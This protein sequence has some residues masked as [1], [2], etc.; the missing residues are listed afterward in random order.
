MKVESKKIEIVPEF[1]PV[2]LKITLETV[3]E[4][5]AFYTIFN[6]TAITDSINMI[7]SYAIRAALTKDNPHLFNNSFFNK[8]VNSIVSHPSCFYQQQFIT[9][10]GERIK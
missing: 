4:M 1:V 7:N 8:I 9:T 3:K 5:Q 2:E 6:F 10:K